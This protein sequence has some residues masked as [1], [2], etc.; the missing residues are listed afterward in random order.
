[1]PGFKEDLC[2]SVHSGIANNP[3]IRNNELQLRDYGY[4]EYIDADPVMHIPFS[5][6]ASITVWRDL[7]RTCETIARFSKK[8]AETFRRMVA[9]FKAYEAARAASRGAS[10]DGGA[11]KI[12]KAGCLAAPHGDVRLRFAL[13]NV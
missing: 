1:M 11:P 6:G 13:R 7:D 3:L 4:G 8:D 9:E 12:P 10:G 5:D 2:S